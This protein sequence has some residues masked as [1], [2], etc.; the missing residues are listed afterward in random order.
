MAKRL[1]IVM[2]DETVTTQAL[3]LDLTEAGYRVETAVDG[4]EAERKIGRV[5]FDLLIAPETSRGGSTDVVEA[6]RRRRPTAKVV[7]MTTQG[8]RRKGVERMDAGARVRKPFDLERFRSLVHEL[9][10][11]EPTPRSAM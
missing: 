10:E 6:F 9:L 7:L 5:R 3:A 11:E 8:G 1:L 4:E 2:D